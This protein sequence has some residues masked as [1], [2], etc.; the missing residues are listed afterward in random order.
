MEFTNISVSYQYGSG[1][2]QLTLYT[3]LERLAMLLIN[4]KTLS[5]ETTITVNIPEES[6]K[7]DEVFIKNWS[8]NEGILEALI[9]SRIVEK[10]GEVPTGF[11][12]AD[13]CRVVHPELLDFLRS[14]LYDEMDE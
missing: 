7:W 11:V 10:I 1:Y 14:T 5:V 6:L 2:L 9:D 3:H 4:R 13:K 12:K 8:E